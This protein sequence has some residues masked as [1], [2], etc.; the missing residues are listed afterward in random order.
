M[1]SRPAPFARRVRIGVHR[2]DCARTDLVQQDLSERQPGR[3]VVDIEEA[4][5]RAVRMD[6]VANAAAHRFAVAVVLRVADEDADLLQVAFKGRRPATG[7]PELV[8]AMS[9]HSAEL[10]G[11]VRGQSSSPIRIECVPAV[12]TQRLLCGPQLEP[13]TIHRHRE[14]AG[15]GAPPVCGHCD[16]THIVG[17]FA[18]VNQ[19]RLRQ[20]NDGRKLCIF[21]VD[22]QRRERTRYGFAALEN[23]DSALLSDGPIEIVTKVH[24]ESVRNLPASPIRGMPHHVQRE[25]RMC[26]YLHGTADSGLGLNPDSFAGPL[27]PDLPTTLERL[28]GHPAIGGRPTIDHCSQNCAEGCA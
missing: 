27:L 14:K 28:D 16:V 10:V 2:Q 7:T 21:P 25:K 6:P 19:R 15:G 5:E 3:D 9:E 1:T 23:A 17:P 8:E 20:Y 11:Q 12:P 24:A 13:S 26:R 18:I 22:R 4:V